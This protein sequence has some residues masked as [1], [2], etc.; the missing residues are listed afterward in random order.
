MKFVVNFYGEGFTDIVNVREREVTLNL[1]GE[2]DLKANEVRNANIERLYKN[3]IEIELDEIQAKKTNLFNETN[4]VRVCCSKGMLNDCVDLVISDVKEGLKKIEHKINEEK[5]LKKWETNNY[6]LELFTYEYVKEQQEKAERE[7][8]QK[9]RIERNKIEAKQKKELE[10]AEME[11]WVKKHGSI[12]LKNC[13]ELGYKANRKYVEER[14]KYELCN[15]EYVIDFEEEVDVSKRI[16][17][18]EEA[19]EMLKGFKEKF[20]YPCELKYVDNE[21]WLEDNEDTLYQDTEVLEVIFLG[22]YVYIKLD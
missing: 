2:L 18:T 6:S 10:R 14:A 22:K 9:E 13:L 7:R 4:K 17:P 11:T 12:Y 5:V 20:K 21:Y 3:S 1:L 19:I 15:Y 8:L 16:N